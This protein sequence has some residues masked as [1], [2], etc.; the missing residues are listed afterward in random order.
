VW[1]KKVVAKVGTVVHRGLGLLR[2]TH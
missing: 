2:V 1:G